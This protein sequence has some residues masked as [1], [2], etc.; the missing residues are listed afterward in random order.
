MREIV[1]PVHKAT[2]GRGE[3]RFFRPP[4][5]EPHQPWHAVDDLHR[6][7]GLPRPIRREFKARLE[8]DWRADVR[9]AF[10]GAGFEFIAPHWM[11][12]GFIGAAEEMGALPIPD[13]ETR[14]AVE[15]AQAMSIMTAHLSGIDAVNY[16]IAAFRNSNKIA[17][18]HPTIEAADVVL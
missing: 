11:A 9:H 16:S 10:T 12:Q 13:F 6:A 2:V 4:F 8:R 18:P 14:Y 5:D 1:K 3:I 17:G 7:L 15:V